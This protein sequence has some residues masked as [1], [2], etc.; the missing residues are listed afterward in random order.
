MANEKNP[1]KIKLDN[2]T[3][4]RTKR[5]LEKLGRGDESVTAVLRSGE[6]VDKPTGVYEEGQR[7]KNARNLAS[8]MD[9]EEFGPGWEAMNVRQMA[10]GQ[11]L[12]KIA[13]QILVDPDYLEKL[14]ENAS[15]ND[16]KNLIDLGV[17]IERTAMMGVLE[18]EKR[19]Q[20]AR[21]KHN[22]ERGGSLASKA[23]KS[24]ELVDAIHDL[25]NDDE[26]EE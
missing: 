1:K 22:E 3:Y 17:K 6:V 16:L 5:R 21:N 26:E 14:K 15:P 4:M 24:P 8:S 13:H 10:L 19:R 20:E 2:A 9:L 7:D 18:E 23:L 12:Q 25:I 11:R